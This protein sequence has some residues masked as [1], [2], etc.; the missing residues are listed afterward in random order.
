VDKVAG[1]QISMLFI[2]TNCTMVGSFKAKR[3]AID[4]IERIPP[5]FWQIPQ[6]KPQVVR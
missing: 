2:H 5:S 3:K 1:E 4:T 6:V